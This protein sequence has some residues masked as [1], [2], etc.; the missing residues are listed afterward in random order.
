M[1]NCAIHTL[2]ASLSLAVALVNCELVENVAENQKIQKLAAK[3]TLYNGNPQ[4]NL[5]IQ[6]FPVGIS[7]QRNY[8][9]NLA[10]SGKQDKSSSTS[11]TASAGK[12]SK[13]SKET[14]TSVIVYGEKEHN[15]VKEAVPASDS[16]QMKDDSVQKDEIDIDV[17]RIPI[18]IDADVETTI[19]QP[20]STPSPTRQPTTPPTYP[21]TMVPTV[22]HADSYSE[23]STTSSTLSPT[24]SPVTFVPR[25]TIQMIHVD[26]PEECIA[27]D[28][29]KSE[30]A[31]QMIECSNTVNG[32][33]SDHWQIIMVDT[34]RF[35]LRH[36]V[37]GLCLPKNPEHPD[38]P[39][40]CFRYS[41]DSVAIADS[42]NGLADC[43][44]EFAATMEWNSNSSSLHLYNAD[45]LSE[46]DSHEAGSNVIF[47]SYKRGHGSNQTQIVMWGEQILMSMP[48]LVQQ[49]SFQASWIMVEV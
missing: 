38:Q 12:G 21:S 36:T 22:A 31:V 35:L 43:H 25:K 45:C 37:S 19:E 47:M 46:T 29:T 9:R 26:A 8:S 1:K 20:A 40:D 2:L 32:T 17:E 44:T 39:F 23:I 48:D 42:I 13:S 14:E 24:L 18:S 33:E 30:S 5:R 34:N 41:G 4:T 6:S 27:Y 16:E 15:E 7:V 49:H 3:D 28:A 11:M 10:K